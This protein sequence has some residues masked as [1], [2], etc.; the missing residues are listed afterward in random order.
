[1]NMNKMLQKMFFLT[2]YT[3]FADSIIDNHMQL[4]QDC[5]YFN[6]QNIL[7]EKR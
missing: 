2:T 6:S 1:M 3:N 5:L 4:L 7:Q